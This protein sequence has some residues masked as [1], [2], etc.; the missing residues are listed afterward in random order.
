M[1]LNKIF[2]K[3]IEIQK[4]Y[5]LI[6]KGYQNDTEKLNVKNEALMNY[7]LENTYLENDRLNDVDLNYLHFSNN[8]LYFSSR[9]IS[10]KQADAF[11]DYIIRVKDLP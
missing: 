4:Y 2:L 11:K 8:V 5:E 9:T 1:D 6:K 10:D 3:E 7:Y